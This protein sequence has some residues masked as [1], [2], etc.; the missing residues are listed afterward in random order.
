MD[1]DGSIPLDGEL[2][3]KLIAAKERW[4]REGRLLTDG[5]M[6]CISGVCRR[7]NGPL[8]TG[9][10]STSGVVPNL[11]TDDWVFSVGGMVETRSDG[12]GWTSWPSPN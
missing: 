2:K 12:L 11:S 1:D 3:S 8:P 9:R 10:S 6:A 4:A 5:P 7:A